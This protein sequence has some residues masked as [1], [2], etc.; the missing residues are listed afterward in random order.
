MSHFLKILTLLL[1]L[2]NTC[3]SFCQN[4]ELSIIT[5]DSTHTKN[6]TNI[7]YKTTHE[8]VK[9]VENEITQFN[10]ALEKE[11]YFNHHTDSIQKTNN[12]Y[13][14]Y[15][16]TPD[17]IESVHISVSPNNFKTLA[18][19]DTLIIITPSELEQKITSLTEVLDNKGQTFSTLTLTAPHIKNN[20]LYANL[21][22]EK[23][24]PR[25]L[26]SVAIVGY[27]KFPTGF[28]RHY[29]RIKQGSTFSKLQ[30]EKKTNLL[31]SLSFIT[32]IKS[33]EISFSKDSTI[34]YLYLEK[35][36]TN[37]F[38]GFIGFNVSE[39]T[40]Q[41]AFN[42]SVN[43]QLNNN[44][45]SGEEIRIYWKNNGSGQ[46]NFQSSVKLPYIFN[47]PITPKASINILKQ[48]SLYNNT[49]LDLSTT[50]PI[51][52]KHQAGIFYRKTNS[53]NTLE[54][55]DTNTIDDYDKK[56]F[57]ISYH[58]NENQTVNPFQKTTEIYLIAGIGN[59]TTSY[60][61]PQQLLE[62]DMYHQFSFS[63]RAKFYI[64]NQ[65]R[66]LFS[67]NILENEYYFFGGI[68]SIRGFEENSLSASIFSTFNTEYRRLLSDKFYI[69]SITDFSYQKSP[70]NHLQNHLIGLGL[71]IGI[72]NKNGYFRLNYALGLS[73]EDA[74]KLNNSKIHVSYSTFF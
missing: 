65:T 28:L 30:I 64:N 33:P 6:T 17:K 5:T 31:N 23:A 48:D 18:L 25:K 49:S 72:L 57:G 62:M 51:N 35:R 63:P 26:D 36:T 37:I 21:T 71:G 56:I 47:S 58:F 38:D 24:T 42:G 7:A 54:N 4:I 53:V 46:S 14:Y 11:G 2:G 39:E 55:T 34:L 8:N 50:Y 52:P 60:K 40:G 69:H 19:T 1:F 59:R 68:N 29:A 70:V 41:V 45:N 22:L 27:N 15:I 67:K 12:K 16:S 61:E 74:S 9:S 20:T 73:I 13:T 10:K 44:L 3:A 66:A 32:Q 43:L